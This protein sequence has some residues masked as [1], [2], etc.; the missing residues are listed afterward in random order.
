[1]NIN[2][3]DLYIDVAAAGSPW[4]GTLNKK[5]I[6]SYRLDLTYPKGMHGINIGA[7]ASHTELPDEFASVLSL[8]CSYEHFMGDADIRFLKESSRI[9]NKSGRYAIIPL[10]IDDTY[11][12]ATSPFLNQAKI[13]IEKEAKKNLERR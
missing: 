8:Q 10:Y 3:N 12:V 7:D 1:L 6:N 4:A 13:T 11:F 5:G 9:L 2:E